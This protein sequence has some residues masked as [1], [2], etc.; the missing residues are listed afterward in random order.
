[1]ALFH[2]SRPRVCWIGGLLMDDIPGHIDF[3]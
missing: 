2:D 3:N 1:M